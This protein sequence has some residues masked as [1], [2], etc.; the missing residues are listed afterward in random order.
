[1]GEPNDLVV[2]SNGNVLVT[3]GAKACVHEF[4]GNGKYRGKFGDISDLKCP[5]GMVWVGGR[6]GECNEGAGGEREGRKLL[7]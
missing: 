1:M 5:T 2:L 7:L 6:V 3:D 4:E